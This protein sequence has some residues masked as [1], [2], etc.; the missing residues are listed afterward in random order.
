MHTST[1]APGRPPGIW[2]D[3]DGLTLRQRAVLEAI[4]ESV[5]T[6]GYPPSMREIGHTVD[7][8]STSS[9]AHQMMALERK[10][11]LH[12]DPQRP[13]AYALA[14]RA[15]ALVSDPVPTPSDD[16]LA[17]RAEEAEREAAVARVP[18]L[19]PITTGTLN[20]AEEPVQELLAM[21]RRA[22][23][24][25]TLFALTV[26]GQSMIDAGIYE[27]DVVTVRAQKTAAHG[28]IVAALPAGE[29][30]S[31]TVKKLRITEDGM[32]LMP[33]N[34]AFQSIPLQSS[35]AILGKVV[36]VLRSL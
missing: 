13:R 34:L 30:S 20:L 32:W 22:V 28:D 27:G 21:P 35:T 19:S 16:Y 3:A 5:R 25:G 24:H 4:T 11:F 1:T 29:G 2:E 7:L 33:C 14:A 6:R 26:T 8:S 9:V 15:L 12:R 18:L 31:P 36:A 23:G 10:G 17:E